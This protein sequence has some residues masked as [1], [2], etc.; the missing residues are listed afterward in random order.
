MYVAESAEDRGRRDSAPDGH[1]V[2][3]GADRVGGL[4][5]KRQQKRTSTSTQ[6]GSRASLTAADGEILESC[7][8]REVLRGGRLVDNMRGKTGNYDMKEVERRSVTVG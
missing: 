2:G 6:L 5:Q 3:H 4:Q 8:R 1:G 7:Q